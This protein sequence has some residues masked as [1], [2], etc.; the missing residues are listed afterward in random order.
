MQVTQDINYLIRRQGTGEYAVMQTVD[1]GGPQF[2]KRSTDGR[3]CMYDSY[4]RAETKAA[5]L[6]AALRIRLQRALVA[7]GHE[8]P[9]SIR[10]REMRDILIQQF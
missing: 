8:V 2:Y 4:E 10:I 6:Y 3:L 7:A 5:L 1:G 9:R